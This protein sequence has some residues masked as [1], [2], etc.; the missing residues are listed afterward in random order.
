MEDKSYESVV[1]LE[2]A[3]KAMEDATAIVIEEGGDVFHILK[4]R[5]GWE[6]KKVR[7]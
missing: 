3:V 4:E 6:L 2:E 1:L 5:F 7:S